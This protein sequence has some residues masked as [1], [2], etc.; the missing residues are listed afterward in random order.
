ME[1]VVKRFV[2]ISYQNVDYVSLCFRQLYLTCLFLK[3]SRIRDKFDIGVT[4]CD[5][6]LIQS[7]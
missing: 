2:V 7:V 3:K 4:F 5:C 1:Y 6:M